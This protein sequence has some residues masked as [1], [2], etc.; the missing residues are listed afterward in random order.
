M[1]R[2]EYWTPERLY[3]HCV[4]S[5]PDAVRLLRAIH[6]WGG[7][8]PGA[9]A[10]T[11]GEDFA[12][13]GA[14]ARAWVASDQHADAVCIDTDA[15]ALSRLEGVERV[16]TIVGDATSATDSGDAD[17]VFVGNFSI[18]YI[19]ERSDLVAYLVKARDRLRSSGV[20]VCDT[21]GGRSAFDLG[22]T[23]RRIDLPD[24]ARVVYTWEQR[25][26]DPLT[27]RVRDVLHFT[28]IRGSDIVAQY[29]DAFV[30]DWRL[31]SVP[32]LRDAMR[33]AGMT[34]TEAFAM[35]PEAVDDTGAAHVRPAGPADVRGETMIVCVAGWTG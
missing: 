22:S 33:D 11:L 16:R 21:Y 6:A 30:Y 31:W 20:F 27:A 10:R 32:E 34:R 35:L 28:L 3:E 23:E 8:G 26:A 2:D 1:P 9:L 29:R 7:G 14:V 17:V 5:A 13:T 19:H 18:G 15:G 4:Q 24:G 12:G 25:E